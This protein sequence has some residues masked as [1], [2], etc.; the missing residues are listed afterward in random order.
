MG[1]TESIFCEIKLPVNDYIWLPLEG[2]GG[3]LVALSGLL[4]S[5]DVNFP[6]I[7]RLREKFD[8]SQRCAGS[9]KLKAQ[10]Q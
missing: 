8:I 9:K 5:V 7:R 2:F 4:Q 6:I 3:C 1:H 10:S